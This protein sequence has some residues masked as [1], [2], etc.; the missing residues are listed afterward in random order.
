MPTIWLAREVICA[1]VA[2]VSSAPSRDAG[3]Q[4]VIFLL[5]EAG[6]KAFVPQ[7]GATLFARVWLWERLAALSNTG[8]NFFNYGFWKPLSFVRSVFPMD[9]ILNTPSPRKTWEH[10]APWLVIRPTFCCP[11]KVRCVVKAQGRV[12]KGKGEGKFPLEPAACPLTQTSW[13]EDGMGGGRGNLKEFSQR[14]PSPFSLSVCLFL[15]CSLI[16][17]KK[18]QQRRMDPTWHTRCSAFRRLI[19]SEQFLYLTWFL[20]LLYW[21]SQVGRSKECQGP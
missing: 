2:S 14:P 4:K 5:R 15:P 21:S 7:E 6:L 12:G 1:R 3:N 10:R 13:E 11:T 8:N 19:L 16:I 18:M 17:M 20:A 9:S